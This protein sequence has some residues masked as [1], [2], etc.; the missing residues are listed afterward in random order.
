MLKLLRNIILFV[1]LI[2][3]VLTFVSAKLKKRK[4]P[5]KKFFTFLVSGFLLFYFI[6][7]IVHLLF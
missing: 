6:S 5:V 1:F 2:I 4:L 7:L 3:V